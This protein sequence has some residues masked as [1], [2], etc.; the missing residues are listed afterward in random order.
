[1]ESQLDI[2]GQKEL[3][4]VSLERATEIYTMEVSKSRDD[5]ITQGKR[6]IDQINGI[7][8]MF[9]VEMK[10]LTLLIVKTVM[11]NSRSLKNVLQRSN[12]NF[13]PNQ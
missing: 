5:K 3:I 4:Q 2:N 11:Y 1:M 6:R 9:K 13:P 12:L 8:D 7:K 10:S